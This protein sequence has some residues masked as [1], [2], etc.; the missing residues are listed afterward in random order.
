M[1]MNFYP[2]SHL[3]GCRGRRLNIFD[4]FLT[5]KTFAATLFSFFFFLSLLHNCIPWIFASCRQYLPT[6][7]RN[8]T[9]TMTRRWR[10]THHSSIRGKLSQPINSSW[11]AMALTLK[12]KAL[13]WY[14]LL[15]VPWNVSTNFY[16]YVPWKADTLRKLVIS[17]S[18]VLQR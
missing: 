17:S 9:K 8:E 3:S 1:E 13:L 15:L 16:P 10:L 7:L 4:F 18:A 2:I 6:R 14:L 12:K 11:E 5:W